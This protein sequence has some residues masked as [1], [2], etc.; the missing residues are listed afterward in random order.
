MT[1]VH[2]LDL[3]TQ[4][5]V[6]SFWDISLYHMSCTRILCTRSVVI[7]FKCCTKFGEFVGDVVHDSQKIC[8]FI[9]R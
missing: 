9:H 4:L 8:Q 7:N 5:R 6:V 3:S 2:L 1:F